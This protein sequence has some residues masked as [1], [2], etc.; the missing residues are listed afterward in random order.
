[1]RGQLLEI[2]RVHVRSEALMHGQAEAEK[3]R[4]FFD[5]LG[6]ELAP[7]SKLSIFNLLRKQEALEALSTGNAQLYFTPADVDLSIE[8]RATNGKKVVQNSNAPG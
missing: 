2:K 7:D 4:A 5:G 8:T 1:M 6:A 3:V